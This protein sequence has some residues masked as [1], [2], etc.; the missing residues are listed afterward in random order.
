MGKTNEDSDDINK[1]SDAINPNSNKLKEELKEKFINWINY[2]AEIAVLNRKVKD[3][4]HTKFS[5]EENMS[6]FN[7]LNLE[8][9]FDVMTNLEAQ[10]SFNKIWDS[11][12]HFTKSLKDLYKLLTDSVEDMYHDAIVN[13][14]FNELV[15]VFNS[16]SYANLSKNE[17]GSAISKQVFRTFISLN[18]QQLF[19]KFAALP[20]EQQGEFHLKQEKDLFQTSHCK[21]MYHEIIAENYAKIAVKDANT[22]TPEEKSFIESIHNLPIAKTKA[23][24]EYVVFRNN[25]LLSTKPDL[26]VRT[27]PQRGKKVAQKKPNIEVNAGVNNPQNKISDNPSQ[28][29]APPE[30]KQPAPP[31]KKPTLP[32]HNPVIP[33]KKPDN[34]KVESGGLRKAL[35][36]FTQYINENVV[37]RISDLVEYG[38]HK[39]NSLFGIAGKTQNN[40]Q[41]SEV[42]IKDNEIHIEE[43]K[44][45][46]N[47]QQAS[48]V[49]TQLGIAPLKESK[50]SQNQLQAS[51]VITQLGIV[52]ALIEESKNP[53]NG[54]HAS[55]ERRKQESKQGKNV[56]PGGRH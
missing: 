25:Y 22:R 32:K 54:Q 48:E 12:V 19:K 10:K 11:E 27:K 37:K 18:E 55:D 36:K 26:N 46:Q 14:D 44:T 3:F 30:P 29:T 34:P 23:L 42:V 47:Q 16:D 15:K 17:D 56:S 24:S 13:S 20:I 1:N 2:E 35:A 7:S 5:T 21:F 6:K 31:E 51:G 52:K 4:D 28:N 43:S 45:S 9:K 38:K 8:D 53:Q 50:N 39:I 49:T 33:E 41:A 40:K